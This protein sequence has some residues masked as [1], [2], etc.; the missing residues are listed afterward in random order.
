MI[1]K[2]P[3]AFLIKHFRAIHGFLLFF[4]CYLIYR[5]YYIAE[6]FDKYLDNKQ[7]ITSI[8]NNID[9]I[10]ILPMYIIILLLVFIAAII[11][12]LLRHKKKPI[13]FYLITISVYL[14]VLISYFYS[15]SFFDSLR[16]VTPDLRFVNIL[17]DIYH[18]LIYI[19][20]PIIAVFFIRMIGFDVRKFDFKHDLLDLG[21]E[22]EDNE[23]V[24]VNF[25]FDKDNFKAKL[26]R[27]LRMAKYFYRENGMV[28]TIAEIVLCVF[29][30]FLVV[31]YF[32]TKEV[33]Y[34]EGQTFETNYFKVKVLDTY[35]TLYDS[36]GN[37]ID[38]DY[39]YVV[40]KLNYIN[41]LNEGYSL[42]TENIILS[43]GD[44]EVSLPD[45]S[46]NKKF[47]EFGVNYSG[48]IIN[49]HESRD[50]VFVYEVPIEYYDDSFM[51]KYLYD[52]KFNKNTQEYKYRKIKINLNEFNEKKQRVSTKSLDEDLSFEGSLLGNTS[53]NIHDIKM[54]D[55]FYYNVT[56]CKNMVCNTKLNSITS[57]QATQFDLTLMRIHFDL[58]FDDAFG[59]YYEN[60]KFIEQFGSIRFEINGK[61]FNNRLTLT[62]VTPITTKNY[63][64]IE[65]RDKVKNADKIYLDFTIRDKVYTYVIRDN[66]ICL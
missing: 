36:S 38:S 24:E 30:I 62:D 40:A 51:I 35:K 22:E 19:Q 33:I 5:S 46:L 18:V 50:F 6:S 32:T 31:N 7:K 41:K 63:V 27:Q 20:I 48:Q 9:S 3:Y 29:V 44:N 15:A 26:K 11:I 28:F 45:S 58:K 60:S 34:N 12:Y 4:A 47:T 14:I 43:Y 17:K 54:S 25:E 64:F 59:E 37:K 61:E 42:N 56:K 53:I 66:L 65:L 49:Q 16:L 8:I 10:V 21:I 52:I 39:F 1:L 2:K 13:L 57:R 23:E 55:T